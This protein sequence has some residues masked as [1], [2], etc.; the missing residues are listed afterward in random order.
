[1]A[2]KVLIIPLLLTVMFLTACNSNETSKT[3]EKDDK[4]E[5][6]ETTEKTN[7]ANDS[8][9]ENNDSTKKESRNDESEKIN[10]EVAAL[11][12]TFLES[13]AYAGVGKFAGK[14]QYTKTFSN[15]EEIRNTLD[16]FPELTEDSSDQEIEK[17]KR[18]LFSLFKE[19]LSNVDV[20]IKQWESMKF[21][22]PDGK[23]EKLQLKENYNVAI[24]LDSSGSMANMEGG[25]TR[26]KLAKEAI[27]QFVEELPEQ[28]NISLRVY[29]HIGTGSAADKKKSCATVEEVYPLGKYDSGKFSK[30]LNQFKPAGWTPMANAI[31][32]VEKDFKKY[33]GKENTNIIYVVSDGVETCGGDPVKTVQSLSESNIDPVVNIIGYQVDNEGL[34]Q[35]KEMAEA[36]KGRYINAEN[37]ADLVSE[38]EQTVDMAEIW[39]DWHRDIKDTLNKLNQTIKTQLNDWHDIQR[40]RIN[41][42]HKNLRAA[43]YYLKDKEILGTRV[44]LNFDDDYTDYYLTIHDEETDIYLNLIES[45]RDSFLSNIEDATDRYLEA[46]Q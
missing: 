33:D 19:D 3:E 30:A 20:P 17:V 7:E 42:E 10:E 8:I 40:E 28:A 32:Q 38:F 36:S 27:Q 2:K 24:L 11:P 18:Q 41:R 39:S 14:E 37:Q 21:D 31:Q 23:T 9:S 5:V 46:V 4:Q 43:V 35:L 13:V 12:T 6:T 34:A 15:Q 16:E 22:D 1:M 25:K 26:L 29:G 44:Y 45:N